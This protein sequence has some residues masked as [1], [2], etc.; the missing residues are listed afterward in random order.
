MKTECANLARLT[1]L[2]ISGVSAFSLAGAAFA[3]S[4]GDT[5]TTPE[6]LDASIVA[7]A[8]SPAVTITD[9]GSL[10]L[11]GFSISCDGTGTGVSLTGIGRILSDTTGTGSIENCETGVNAQGTGSHFIQGINSTNNTLSGITLTSAANLILDSTSDINSGIGL[12]MLGDYNQVIN[13]QMNS[14][15][16]PGIEI[17]GSG[18]VVNGNT[19]SSNVVS[20]IVVFG[21]NNT[22]ISGNTA[23]DNGTNGILLE[24]YN[25]MNVLVVGNTAK[26]NTGNDLNDQNVPPCSGSI[27]ISN[28]FED[29][30]D[31]CIN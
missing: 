11:N 20:G 2:T 27:W 22:T 29:A 24:A 21:S 28:V 6:T 30:N 12:R 13:S 10:D 14:N 19:V 8:I 9:A 25:Q 16:L 7:C 1:L 4:C 18:S 31:T 5:V 3:V 26:G 23:N 17:V 15:A